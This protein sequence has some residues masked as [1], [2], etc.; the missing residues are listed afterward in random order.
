MSCIIHPINGVRDIDEKLRRCRQNVQN[1]EDYLNSHL[2]IPI[3][4][5]ERTEIKQ[6]LTRWKKSLKYYR[7]QKDDRNQL[8][9]FAPNIYWFI[10]CVEN[11]NF[12]SR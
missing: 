4:A 8:Q 10:V 1:L 6:Q 2:T 7:S 12:E 11:S 9:I 3:P 5:E